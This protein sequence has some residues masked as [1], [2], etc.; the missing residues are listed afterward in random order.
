MSV[1]LAACFSA[2]LLFGELTR[3]EDA[4]ATP[5]SAAKTQFQDAL[6]LIDLWLDAQAAYDR[7]PALSAGVVIGQDLVWKKG[8]G[9]ID[10]QRQVATRADTIYGICSISKLFTSVAVMQLWESGRFSL[11]DDVGKIL[12]SLAIRRSDPDSGPITIRSLLTHSSGFP[13]EA[14]FPYWSPPEF[15]FPTRQEMMQRL[16]EQQTFMRTS[17]HFQ[18]SNL[19]MAVLGEVVAKVSG[20]PYE[21]YLQNQILDPLKLTDTKSYMPKGLYGKRLAQGFGPLRRDGGRDLLRLYDAKG[22]TPAAGLSSTV[23]DLARFAS[24]QFRLR[25]AGG[26]EVLKVSTLREMQR[27]QWTDPDGKTTVGLGFFVSREG[28]NTVAGHSGVCPGYLTSLALVLEDEVAVIAMANANDNQG[29]GRY[30]KPMRQLVLKGL[31]LPVAPQA[32][33]NPD[34]ASYAGRYGSQPWK[35]E[36]VVVPWGAGLARLSLP[37]GDPVGDM[38]LLR[39]VSKDN[40]REVRDDDSLGAELIFQRDATGQVTGYRSWGH[41]S[42]RLAH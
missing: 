5:P 23:E 25:K 19:A 31:K 17:D 1:F 34:L 3:A 2:F 27:V 15:N 11:D 4:P 14:S 39:H 37:T 38:V 9:T 40:F 13:R 24:W 35:S 18:Y 6:R 33:D 29:L 22:I 36:N 26:R 28:K 32:A 10:Q 20:M 30:T 12:P 41:L 16:G 7:V 8:Y 42:A 21:E